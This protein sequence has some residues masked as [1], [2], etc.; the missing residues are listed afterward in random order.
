[1]ID[2]ALASIN[3]SESDT[4]VHLSA[5]NGV[6]LELAQ[7]RTIERLY[8]HSVRVRR[9]LGSRVV[10]GSRSYK[11]VGYMSNIVSI[12]DTGE[13]EVLI[14]LRRLLQR[15][16]VFID[17]GVNL[18]Q[19]L[20]RVLSVDGDRRYL[21]FEPQIA[22][23]FYVTRFLQDNGLSF[24]QVLPIGLGADNGIRKFWSGGEAD[25][26]ASMVEREGGGRETI[27]PVRRGDDVLAELEIS[28][29]AAIKIDVEGA[30]LEVMHGLAD[31][32][33]KERPP[34]LFEVL[35]N[36]TGA[37][38]TPLPADVAKHQSDNA[39]AI[40]RFLTSLGY[41]V[42]L[43]D[44]AGDEVPVHAF[45]LNDRDGFIGFN[46]VAHATGTN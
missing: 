14:V 13:K 4:S 7:M 28:E 22:A 6:Q 10:V 43:I 29:I 21:G 8:Q 19:T 20:G 25:T 27:I 17:V 33:R 15:P 11:V 36:F 26:M 45:D 44:P 16:G 41:R 32:L 12:D 9:H 34:I 18:G 30:E 31:T 38:R 24:A 1:L 42:F 37:E 46:Y 40:M 3:G 39:E 2:P 23:C 5:L 35:P